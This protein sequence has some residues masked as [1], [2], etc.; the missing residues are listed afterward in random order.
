[1]YNSKYAILKHNRGYYTLT[2]SK[3]NKSQTY[4]QALDSI[5]IG[6]ANEV[7]AIIAE[8]DNVLN[9]SMGITIISGAPGIGKTYLVEHAIKLLSDNTYIYGKSLQGEDREITSISEIIDQIVCHISTLPNTTFNFIHEELVNNIG[10]DLQLLSSISAVFKNTFNINTSI[11]LKDFSKLKYR[12]KNVI[13]NFISISSTYLFPLIIHIDD[14]QWS[15]QLTFDVIKSLISKKHMLNILLIISFRDNIVVENI[16]KLKNILKKNATYIKLGQL[17]YQLLESYID[18]VFGK[19]IAG[20]Q[21]LARLVNGFSLGNPFFIKENLKILLAE[22]IIVFSDIS[23]EWRLNIN[24]INNFKVSN[25]M[26]NIFK[27][28][29]LKE[30]ENNSYLLNMFSCLGGNIEYDILQTT[31]NMDTTTLNDNIEKLLKSA[32]LLRVVDS[33][34]T[35]KLLFSHDI[36]YD[37]IISNLNK[38]DIQVYHYE[39]A[40]K[41]LDNKKIKLYTKDLFLTTHLLKSNKQKVKDNASKWIHVLFNTGSYKMEISLIESALPIF[42]LCKEILPYCSNTD[43]NFYVNL[44]LKLAECLYLSNRVKECTTIINMLESTIKEEKLVIAIK[45]IQLNIHHYNR[46]HKKVI[47][48][49]TE[50]LKLLGIRFGKIWLLSDLIYSRFIYSSK[51]INS[52]AYLDSNH[53]EKASVVFETLTLMNLSATLLGDDMQAC[54]GLTS[55]LLSAKY[56]NDP[57]VFVGY[58]SY[59]YVLFSIWND[60]QKSEL[61]Q[62]K[63]IELLEK[64]HHNA[65]KAMV[66]FIIG[67]FLAHWSKPIQQADY[68]L[69][70]SIK[71]GE[72]NGDFLF[73]GYSITTSMDTKSFMGVNLSKCLSFIKECQQNFPEIEQYVTS[74]NYECHTAHILALKNGC[75]VFSHNIIGAKYP[76][77]TSFEA[78]TEETLALEKCILFDNIELGYDI[79]K[80]VTP[81]I[82]SAK[83][84]ICKI[85]IIFNCSLIRIAIHSSL[86]HIEKHKNIKKIKKHLSELEHWSTLQHDNFYSLY[87]LIKAEYD[88]N[89]R[90]N[91][92]TAELYNISIKE[93]KAQGNLKIAALANLKAAKYYRTNVDLSQFYANQSVSLF[94]TWGAEYMCVKISNMYSLDTCAIT[95]K[96]DLTITNKNQNINLSDFIEKTEKYTKNTTAKLLLETIINNGFATY[97][98]LVYEKMDELFLS[99]EITSG[100]KIIIYKD[101]I[102]INHVTNISHKIVR[103]VGRTSQE[104]QI[105]SLQ[106]NPTFA[107]DP[108][109]KNNSSLNIYCIPLVYRSIFTGMLYIENSTPI[110]EKSILLIKSLIPSFVIKHA[111]TNDMKKETDNN[112]QINLT[113]RELDILKLVS[114]GLSNSEICIK[115]N[116]TLSTTKK[117]LCSIM[118]KLEADNRIKAVLIAKDFKII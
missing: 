105:S 65:N 68:Y 59:A 50:I 51:K 33:N 71:F 73:I 54:I 8:Y 72:M 44:H 6:R 17:D 95:K 100:K 4:I 93:A 88:I 31:V 37:I 60:F 3:K 66:Y 42:E 53:D 70:E 92:T 118:G 16:E 22:N 75:D 38:N 46:E 74:Y 39:I 94:K 52:I 55:A 84:L 24:K 85:S 36:I 91:T 7:E 115:S 101:M 77:L 56:S 43:N 64:S 107:S 80:V 25:D 49:G 82:K 89:I 18:H 109:V 86:N 113:A 81:K 29:F 2:L 35:E 63:I 61:M 90:A 28:N 106:N 27:N 11:S 1:M 34:G 14:L 32:V 12:F 21:Q 96:T 116:I 78:L 98:C 97:C 15:N 19:N 112:N 87:S 76:K 102:N 41:I 57:N 13:L 5:F 111:R 48:L 69:H 108:Y 10:E 9:G 67:A 58:V 40:E 104:V 110:S 103:Y 99:H 114:Q 20:K 45:I 83:G 23:Q 30:H 62:N 79:V 47:S 117:H 26:E